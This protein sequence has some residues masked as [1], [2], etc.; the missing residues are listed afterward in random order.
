MVRR[1]T[2]L[3]P[4][5]I[6]S[7]TCEE[8]AITI[9]ARRASL[10][11]GLSLIA[12]SV[13]ARELSRA[14]RQVRG[15]LS[16]A[17]VLVAISAVLRVAEIE[18]ELAH[19]ETARATIREEIEDA[20]QV[21]ATVSAIESR[22]KLLCEIRDNAVRWTDAIV[23]LAAHLPF[24]AHLAELSLGGDSLTM[25]GAATRAS[26][27]LEQLREAPGVIALRATEPI[28]AGRTAVRIRPSFS[29]MV[30]LATPGTHARQP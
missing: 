7:L 26:D 23:T 16:V 17:A 2:G 28:R 8:P 20:T 14:G 25:A 3:L 9:A 5:A 27:V 18:R 1:I 4:S 12:P 15:W 6:P 22:L 11:A 21:R 30:R 24:S 10:A 29:L 13:L 19:V